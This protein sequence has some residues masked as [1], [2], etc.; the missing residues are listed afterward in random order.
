MK[1]SVGWTVLYFVKKIVFVNKMWQIAVTGREKGKNPAKKTKKFKHGE[2]CTNE[3]PGP[4][5]VKIGDTCEK[6]PENAASTNCL[7]S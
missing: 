4:S 6:F 5:E 7:N 1:V 3:N 2:P